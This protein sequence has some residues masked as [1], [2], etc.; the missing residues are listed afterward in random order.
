MRLRHI[1]VFHAIMRTGS[2]SKAAQLLCV[3]Q[4][5]VS[6]ALAHAEQNLGI[7]LF[8][9][10]HGR[11]LPT[12]EAELLFG[13]TQK[14]QSSLERIRALARNLA[15]QP[16]GQLRVGCLPSLGLSLIPQ[17]VKA[18]RDDYPRVAL[19]IQ[20]LHTDALLNALLTRDLDVA[21]AID[22]PARP[23]ITSAELGRTAVVSVGPPDDDAPDAPLSLH[24]FMEGESIGIGTEDPL[25]D[26]IGNALEAFG[27][28]RVTMVEAHTWYVARALAARGVGRVLLDELTARAPGEPVTIRP[29]EPAL[30]VGVFALWRDGGLD[31]HAGA[32][33]VDALR[34]PF[35]EPSGKPPSMRAPGAPKRRAR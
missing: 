22:P 13:E 4:P 31:S 29:I 35:G 33:F 14:L 17:A 1:E 32:T 3:S 9:R 34:A 6:K 15:L 18:F 16:E 2:L 5:A 7:R 24:A 8:S 25:G 11:L 27:E 30:S 28:D 23:G 12:R 21:V 10:A 19:K 20:T 26:A